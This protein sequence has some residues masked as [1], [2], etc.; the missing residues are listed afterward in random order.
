MNDDDDRD[1]LRAWRD[2]GQEG[3]GE[4]LDR[5][6]LSAARAHQTRRRALPLLAVLAACLLLF[7]FSMERQQQSRPVPVAELDT[8]TIGLYEGRSA[9]IS[10]SPEALQEIMIHHAPV[11]SGTLKAVSP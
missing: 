10:A 8:A 1:L 4:L 5:R 3:P 7:V 11:Q 6:I 2:A 9:D